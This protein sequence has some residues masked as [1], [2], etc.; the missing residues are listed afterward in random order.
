MISSLKAW[1]MLDV[2]MELTENQAWEMVAWLYKECSQTR[3]MP[4]RARIL[5]AISRA[6]ALD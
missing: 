5:W 4:S 2:L 1:E 6:K 3:E